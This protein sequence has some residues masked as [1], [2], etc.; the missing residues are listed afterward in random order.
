MA[1]YIELTKAMQNV[2][3]KIDYNGLAE[4]LTVLSHAAVKWQANW[5]EIAESITTQLK[6]VSKISTFEPSVVKALQKQL[7]S[8]QRVEESVY[9][10]F[11]KIDAESI[12]KAL[13]VSNP[14]ADY[15]YD[16]LAKALQDSFIRTKEKQEEIKENKPEAILESIVEEVQE[17]YNKA[18]EII[19]KD[20][21]N[22]EEVEEKKKIT[23]DD[24]WKIIERI[25]IIIAIIVGLREMFGGTDAK[26]CNSVQETNN[27]Y[28]NELEI[29]AEYWNMFQYRIINRNSVMPRIAPDCASRVAGH[30]SEGYVVQKLKKYRKWIQIYWKDENGNACCGWIQNYKLDEFKNNQI[31]KK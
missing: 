17:E 23:A 5:E 2:I 13:K 24:I 30:L 7:C 12:T 1:D 14:F 19:D 6:P 16:V 25:G 27:Y 26:I 29:D 22:R 8:W 31:K 11:S 15:D 21:V 4:T 10:A 20:L 18:E 3:P 28:I 9:D